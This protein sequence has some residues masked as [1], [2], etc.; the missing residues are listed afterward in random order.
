MDDMAV[1]FKT[2]TKRKAGQRVVVTRGKI[3]EAAVK[4]W[5]AAGPRGFTIRKLAARLEVRPDD[6]PRVRQRGHH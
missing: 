1:I 6:D 2:E 4:L 5:E 3:I